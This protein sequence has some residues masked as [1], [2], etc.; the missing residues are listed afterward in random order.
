MFQRIKTKRVYELVVEQIQ[1][2]LRKGDLRPGDKLMSERELADMLGVSRSAVREALSALDFL[3]VLE[4]RQGEGTFIADVSSQLLLEHLAVFVT[5][6][7][8]ANLELLELRKILEVAAAEMAAAR[9]GALDHEKMA[10]ALR[11]MEQDVH[12]GILGESNDALF[13]RCIVESTQNK[14][15][16]KS[17]VLLSDLVVQNMRVSRQFLFQRPGNR[18]RLYNQ[19]RQVFLAI[20]EGNSEKAGRAM[21]DHLEFVERELICYGSRP[22]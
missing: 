15:L 14:M 5:I 12:S 21:V 9:A 18:E 10:E 13:H 4:S 11:L 1:E 17:M 8:E 7:R 16:T 2:H 19:H 3:G 6:D 22:E 20:K